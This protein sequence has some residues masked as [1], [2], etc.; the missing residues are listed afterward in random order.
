MVCC[1]PQLPLVGMSPLGDP[2]C[3]STVSQSQRDAES[4]SC[5][6]PPTMLSLIFYTASLHFSLCLTTIF[7]FVVSLRVRNISCTAKAFINFVS[8]RSECDATGEVSK[9]VLCLIHCLVVAQHSDFWGAK[10]CSFCVKFHRPIVAF[11]CSEVSEGEVL[12][13]HREAVLPYRCLSCVM[14]LDRSNSSHCFV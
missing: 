4:S 14:S 12:C 1:I 3:A 2:P 9:G 11:K 8:L 13:K 5:Q 7:Y 6:S 10:L